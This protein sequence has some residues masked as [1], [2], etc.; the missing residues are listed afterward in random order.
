MTGSMIDSTSDSSLSV[1]VLASERDPDCPVSFSNALRLDSSLALSASAPLP[2]GS[3]F[4]RRLVTTLDGWTV[5]VA[6][7]SDSG[8]TGEEGK[9]EV[10]DDEPV[11]EDEARPSL[12]LGSE[13]E[14][15]RVWECFL[16]LED[17]SSGDRA[18]EISEP[19]GKSGVSCE[20]IEGPVTTRL[21]GLE[22]SETEERGVCEIEMELGR[23]RRLPAL[24]AEGDGSRLDGI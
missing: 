4:S 21:G 24:G 13:M 15:D 17:D 12:R 9:L 5:A 2:L 7:E 16:V 6:V 11:N 8:E 20:G 1:L 22:I 18:S 19:P 10:N 23:A 3:N 14:L